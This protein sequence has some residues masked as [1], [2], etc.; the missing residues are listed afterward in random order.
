MTSAA[1]QVVSRKAIQRLWRVKPGLIL[2][3]IHFPCCVTE[4]STLLWPGIV[5]TGV[6]MF[7]SSAVHSVMAAKQIGMIFSCCNLTIGK[8]W[9]LPRLSC[10]H[11]L[12]FPI[13][14]GWRFVWLIRCADVF[15]VSTL[16]LF[17]NHACW[18]LQPCALKRRRT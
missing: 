9:T 16:C 1:V 12:R 3:H 15:F 11:Q 6:A 8:I 10:Y 4:V 17:Q 13:S 14:L 5:A 18:W 7:I 2:H